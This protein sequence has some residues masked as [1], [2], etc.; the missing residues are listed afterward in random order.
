MGVG[1]VAMLPADHVDAAIRELE[2]RGIPTW[3]LGEVTALEGAP[4][5]EGHE[6]VSG[7]KGVTGGAV[8]IVGE[9]PRG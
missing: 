7:A 8:Q 2:Q 9:H 3:V 4:V 1:F 5:A 6:V